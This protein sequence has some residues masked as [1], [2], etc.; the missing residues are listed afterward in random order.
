MFMRRIL[1]LMLFC[2]SF[3]AAADL[4]WMTDFQKATTLSKETNKPIVILF[5]G[6]DW[7][8]WCTKVEKEIFNTPD[9]Q[10]AT[11][12]KFIFVKAD[13]PLNTDLPIDL[14]LQNEKLKNQYGVKGFP[15]I[16]VISPSGELLGNLGYKE[17]GGTKFAETLLN[18]S[19]KKP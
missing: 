3:L 6:S 10:A 12:N 17:G 13:F 7:C 5:T 2:C 16:V 15:A 4:K 8:I 19:A 9:F 14:I 18:L 11:M 1:F